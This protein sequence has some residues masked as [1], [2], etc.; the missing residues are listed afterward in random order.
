[1][2]AE[3]TEGYL[4]ACQEYASDER[5]FTRH[6]V[7]S[8]AVFCLCAWLT[9]MLTGDGKTASASVA[10]ISLIWCLINAD[11]LIRI[12]GR[13]HDHHI[14]KEVSRNAITHT[15]LARLERILTSLREDDVSQVW[16]KLEEIDDHV[17]SST[18]KLG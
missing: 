14:R 3:S 4:D 13:H 7:G 11:A 17:T 6:T 16:S 8:A 15:D 1:M 9:L 18:L 2:T 12:Q 10:V 5:Y